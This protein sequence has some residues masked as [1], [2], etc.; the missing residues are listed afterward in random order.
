MDKKNRTYVFKPVEKLVETKSEQCEI[1]ELQFKESIRNHYLGMRKRV[2]LCLN[3]ES[4]FMAVWL[5]MILAA[6]GKNRE[7]FDSK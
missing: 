3:Q 4:I 5:V 6:F 1:Q 7:S 2:K